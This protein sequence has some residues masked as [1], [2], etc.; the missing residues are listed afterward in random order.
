MT[1]AHETGKR[2]FVGAGGE[3]DHRNTNK[4]PFAPRKL[5]NKPSKTYDALHKRISNLKRC[6]HFKSN[7]LLGFFYLK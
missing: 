4:N 6:R 2:S 7:E 3:Y 1:R 5:G